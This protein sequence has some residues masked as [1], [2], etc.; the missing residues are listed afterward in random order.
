VIVWVGSKLPRVG[1]WTSVC[2]DQSEELRSEVGCCSY[3]VKRVHLFFPALSVGD[4]Q[5]RFLPN[6]ISNKSHIMSRPGLPYRYSS[7]SDG[8]VRLLKLISH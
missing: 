7:L 5:P 6:S 1:G 3:R 2:L 4:C 8:S